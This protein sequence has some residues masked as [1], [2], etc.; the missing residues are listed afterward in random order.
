MSVNIRRIDC[1]SEAE[2]LALVR[3]LRDQHSLESEMVTARQRELTE[4]VFG[5]PLSPLRSVERICREVREQGFAAVARFSRCFDDFELTPSGL[6]VSESELRTAHA[7]AS[8]ELLES[9]RHIRDRILTFQMGLVQTDAVWRQDGEEIRVRYRPVRRVGIHVPGGNA[10]YPSTVLMTAIPAQAAG[11]REIAVI[12]PPTRFGSNNPALLA[13][14]YE[15]GI[16]EVYRLGGAHGIAA[17]AYGIEGLPR[18]D[19]IVGPG[20]LFVTLAK[21]HV[22]GTVGIDLLA[23]PT[24]LVIVA[25]DSALPQYLAADMLAQAE[26][27][28]GSSILITWRAELLDAVEEALEEQLQELERADLT[29]DSLERFGALV[30]TRDVD[31][32]ITLANLL[33]PEHLQICA[34]QAETLADRIEHAGAI[35]LGHATPEAVGDYLAGPSHV[36]PTSGTARFASGLSANDF[37]RRTSV[38]RFSES[39]LRREAEHILR[40]ANIECLPAHGQSVLRRLT[41]ETSPSE[42]WLGTLRR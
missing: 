16:R 9:V 6:R 19:M 25:D 38:I 13:V 4:R 12:A 41:A 10:A 3:Q 5:E 18:V 32:A 11:V 22:F 31:Q 29:R 37:L 27:A 36:L 24:E 8:A 1:E 23:G 39:A 21:K 28:P 20:N 35:F 30:H 42:T 14:C 26:H 7:Q 2:G 40:L 15:L 34:R 17:L 33:A